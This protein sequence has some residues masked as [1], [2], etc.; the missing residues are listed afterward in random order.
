MKKIYLKYYSHLILL[1]TKDFMVPNLGKLGSI[2]MLSFF[3]ILN[4]ITLVQIIVLN[5]SF[6]KDNLSKIINDFFQ[7]YKYH[8]V[9]FISLLMIA[10]NIMLFKQAKKI[11]TSYDKIRSGLYVFSYFI[12]SLISWYFAM[13][14][15]L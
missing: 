12:F 10:N 8:I 6:F 4:L 3:N 9:I 11:K 15:D 7:D 5:K 13:V 2:F 14:Y 1:T